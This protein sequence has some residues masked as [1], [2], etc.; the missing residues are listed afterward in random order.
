[1][2]APVG[3][4]GMQTTEFRL[5]IKTFGTLFDL[6]TSMVELKLGINHQLKITGKINPRKWTGC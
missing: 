3:D 2:N 6:K 5:Q 4:A 1:M